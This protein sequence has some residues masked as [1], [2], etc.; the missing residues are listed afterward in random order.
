MARLFGFPQKTVIRECEA[1]VRDFAG[2][3]VMRRAERPRHVRA[4]DF[5]IRRDGAVVRKGVLPDFQ[6]AEIGML[7]EPPVVEIAASQFPDDDVEFSLL[8]GV[9]CGRREP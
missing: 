9:P 4:E 2:I 3:E 1:E 8:H 6:H 7:T 5:R